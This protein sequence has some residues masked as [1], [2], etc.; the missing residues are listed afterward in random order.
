MKATEGGSQPLGYVPLTAAHLA[1]DECRRHLASWDGG[2]ADL[3]VSTEEGARDALAFAQ[4]A[5]RAYAQIE[6]E[7][8]PTK[9]ERVRC[10]SCGQLSIHENPTTTVGGTTRVECQHCGVELTRI[11][12]LSARWTGSDLCSTGLH[13]SCDRAQCSC[14]CHRLGPAS[15]QGGIEA[16]FDADLAAL[17]F[18]PRDAWIAH[19]DETITKENAA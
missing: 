19:P 17:G 10:P 14:E 12:L 15:R 9:F 6:V 11:R 13:V 5:R 8:R 16:L 4:A 18:T 1:L 7:E 3:W 2:R